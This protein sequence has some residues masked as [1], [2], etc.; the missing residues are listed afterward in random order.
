[1]TMHR[2]FAILS[3]LS[4]LNMEVDELHCIYLGTSK[5]FFGVVLWLLVYRILHGSPAENIRS[6]WNWILDAYK[7]LD[8]NCS[9]HLQCLNL[10]SFTD[11]NNPD[12]HY[13]K[14]KGKGA[15]IK[16][17]ARPLLQVW[18]RCMDPANNVHI[19]V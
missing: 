1:M 7:D 19:K 17:F 4:C 12:D 5:W 11:P 16:H 2:L 8:I 10:K 14:M 18:V 3:F 13:P 6:V 9:L 15:Q